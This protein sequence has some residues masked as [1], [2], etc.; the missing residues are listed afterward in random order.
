ML[1]KFLVI[2]TA[3]VF[4]TQWVISPAIADPAIN[5]SR[6][7]AGGL[8][9]SQNYQIYA[10][11]QN[12]IVYHCEDDDPNSV[13]T[14]TTNDWDPTASLPPGMSYD[15]NTVTISGVATT[16]GIY[17]LPD[18]SCHV[19]ANGQSIDVTA[20]A[21]T[22][23]VLRPPYDPSR[24]NITAG[25]HTHTSYE[26]LPV[27]NYYDIDY[28]CVDS[29]PWAYTTVTNQTW[30]P[31][32]PEGMTLDSNTFHISGTPSSPG[33][34]ILGT[35]TCYAD[36]G[37][38]GHAVSVETGIISVY[39][40][41]APFVIDDSQ[42]TAGGHTSM[43]TE[44]IHV[45]DTVAID[46]GCVE[47]D[48]SS[49]NAVGT[50][51]WT[52]PLEP[53]PGLD[54]NPSTGRLSG[55]PTA[56]GYYFL[57]MMTC[58]IAVGDHSV[59]IAK[60]AGAIQ[61]LEADVPP[62][63]PP[64]E[65]APPAAELR[66]IPQ[67]DY[68]CH[69]TVDVFY[70]LGFL[71]DEGSPRLFID[72]NDAEY[73][74]TLAGHGESYHSSDTFSAANFMDSFPVNGAWQIPGERDD[75]MDCWDLFDFELTYTH[76]GVVSE[77][78]SN[79][80]LRILDNTG[81][82]I[83]AYKYLVDGVCFIDFEVWI[84]DKPYPDQDS[85]EASALVSYH[86]WGSNADF[87]I[88]LT[89]I[90]LGSGGFFR[91]NTATRSIV[92]GTPM[93]NTTAWALASADTPDCG[94][95]GVASLDYSIGPDNPVSRDFD[96]VGLTSCGKGEYSPSGFEQGGE[97]CTLAPIGTYVNTTRA[98]HFTAC[99]SGMTTETTGSA[100]FYDCFKPIVQ[101]FKTLT[102]LKKMKF[103]KS[104][105]LP[106]TTDQGVPMRVRAAGN[107]TALPV[108]VNNVQRVKL[109]AAKRAGNCTLTL[110]TPT[111]GRYAP[112]AKT[113]TVKVTKTGK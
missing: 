63:D 106:I 99:P 22:I 103:G 20:T 70:P 5:T 68:M 96:V 81:N 61:V 28:G 109:V 4:S 73:G 113:L 15:P 3:L 40:P 77:T 111:V 59:E 7:S 31:N 10:G 1:R 41:S 67:Q 38:N 19:E 23:E 49:P 36:T 69:F 6:I 46:Y 21:A 53:I 50:V 66:V 72:D 51:G 2:L 89:D 95:W 74:V 80:N 110:D 27:G 88:K 60:A 98:T 92:D 33:T 37:N 9:T 83:E 58:F 47:G 82:Y 52:T 13:N 32:L 102:A 64:D 93:F 18:V 86:E 24:T 104:I 56:T 90:E 87:S 78:A 43:S 79:S 29:D 8:N 48:P 44:I 42:V 30:T 62:V 45:G 26:S 105:L 25:G 91:Y 34:Y 107:C 14:V 57:P 55:S 65:D 76:N 17:D 100:S 71:P 85:T 12:S 94:K 54:Y 35:M 84:A 97:S 11:E 108:M 16:V 75:F 112:V 39:H 101:T